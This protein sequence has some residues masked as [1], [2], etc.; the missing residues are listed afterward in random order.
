ME[1]LESEVKKNS[2]K[3]RA[4]KHRLGRKMSEIGRFLQ[5]WDDLAPILEHLYVDKKKEDPLC[6]LKDGIRNVR[7]VNGD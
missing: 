3:D 6:I 5:W 4:A 7:E 1:R 2:S